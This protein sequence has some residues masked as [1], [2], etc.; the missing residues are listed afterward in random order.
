MILSPLSK[1]LLPKILYAFAFPLPN[2]VHRSSSA[3][4]HQCSTVVGEKRQR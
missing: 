2:H 3:V 4:W 1:R